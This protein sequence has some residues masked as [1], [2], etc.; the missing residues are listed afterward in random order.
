MKILIGCEFSGT[1]R[2][3]FAK[4]G[5]DAWS[6]DLLPSDKPGQHYEGDI[7]AALTAQSWDIVILHPPCTCLC[8]SGNSTYGVGMI[9]HQSRLDS[10]EWTKR[11][12]EAAKQN[13]R[14]VALENPA[15]VLAA[16]IG[17]K[18]QTIQPYEF[19][20]MEQKQTWLWLWGLPPLT[21]TKD[22]KSE[23]M[24]LPKNQRQRLHYLPPSADRW[25]IRS[26]TFTG[27]ASAMAE[28]WGH[29]WKTQIK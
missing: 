2:D 5:H 28:Q 27:I 29:L 6:C 16:A 15:N 22:V 8:L 25:K 21:A 12:W 11:L 3:A 26:T 9:K 13:S 24:K 19:G 20:H 1:V 7:M 4:R 17:K 14:G 18:S 23:M 10:I